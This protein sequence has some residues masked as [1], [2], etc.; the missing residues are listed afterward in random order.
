M[1]R[2]FEKGLFLLVVRN[3]GKTIHLSYKLGFFQ[4]KF[5]APVSYFTILLAL[6]EGT[7]SFPAILRM[8]GPSQRLVSAGSGNE[9]EGRAYAVRHRL[10]AD[11][12]SDSGA[13]IGDIG[14]EL[15]YLGY[16]SMRSLRRACRLTASSRDVEYQKGLAGAA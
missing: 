3:R 1:R 6:T 4:D 2:V 5:F 7:N 14:R 12:M 11:V 10:Q 13:A 15:H 9:S 8:T 16:H